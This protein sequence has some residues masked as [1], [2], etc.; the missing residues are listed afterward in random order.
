VI[1]RRVVKIGGSLLH[2]ERLLESLSSW[3]E[4][5]APA[6]NLLIMGGGELIDQVRRADAIQP[7][8]PVQVHWQCIDLLDATFLMASSWFDW[9]IIRTTDEFQATLE[10]GFRADKPTLVCVSSFYRA[11]LP[12]PISHPVPLD[13]RTTSDTIAAMLAIQV[14]ADEVVL[15]KSCDIDPQ[16]SVEQLSLA[17][18]VDEALPLLAPYTLIRVEKLISAR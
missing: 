11:D 6:Q 2:Q 10:Q 14:A 5:H 17:G 13:W 12:H 9:A 18:V 7:A 8:D 1:P 16:A 15:L 4:R 3:L